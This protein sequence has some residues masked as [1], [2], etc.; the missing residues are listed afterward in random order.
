MMVDVVGD[1]ESRALERGSLRP[2]RSHVDHQV[3]H[4]EQSSC[5]LRAASSVFL[6]MW[7]VC[8]LGCIL[9][10]E[11]HA[12][13]CEERTCDE[14]LGNDPAQSTLPRRGDDNFDA[15]WSEKVGGHDWRLDGVVPRWKGHSL[16]AWQGEIQINRQRGSPD[17]LGWAVMSATS[18]VRQLGNALAKL[19]IDAE[20]S[21]SAAAE[22]LEID[23]SD[24]SDIECGTAQ[25]STPLLA[26]MARLYHTSP[27]LVVK[28]YLADRR[29]HHRSPE[30]LPR[31]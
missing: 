11:A 12:R 29:V 28:A 7:G 30:I 1:S 13:A 15:R 31:A 27:F 14:N 2:A 21:S 6:A 9:R 18:R 3:I 26:N 23:E 20:L 5:R 8:D 22:N 19:R 16:I 10:G 4:F 17:D 24:L 25:A